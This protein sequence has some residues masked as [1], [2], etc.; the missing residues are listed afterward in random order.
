MAIDVRSLIVAEAQRQGVDP[1]IAVAVASRESGIC[2]WEGCITDGAVKRGG[3]GEVGLFQLMPATAAALG[4][5]PFDLYGNITG[6]IAYLR[7]MYQQFGNW[8]DAVAAYNCGPGCVAQAK[9]GTRTLPASTVVYANWVLAVGG[10]GSQAFNLSTTAATPAA[11]SP[12]SS[13]VSSSL[14]PVLAIGFV[15]LAI[16]IY[17]W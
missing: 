5:D 15:G 16:V 10:K 8:P 13:N 2:Q 9:A 12:A 7:Q 11:S 14:Y 1:G 4:V 3:S 6:G 17:E